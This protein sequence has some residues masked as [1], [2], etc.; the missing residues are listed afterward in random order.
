MKVGTLWTNPWSSKELVFQRISDAIRYMLGSE[1]IAVWNC[2]DDM[3]AAWEGEGSSLKF[4]TLCA[5]IRDL[6][7][8]LNEKKVEPPSDKMTIM[9]IEINIPL[10][11]ISIPDEKL[12]EIL[13]HAMR[14]TSRLSSQRDSYN[15]F[16]ESYCTL[17]R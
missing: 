3:F 11:T 1:K 13:M 2:I 7:L 17:A 12:I 14:L 16:S 6:G 10:R 9:G 4:H 15:P 8:S 5:L